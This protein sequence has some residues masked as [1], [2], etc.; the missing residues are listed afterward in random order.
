[1]EISKV[2]EI[3]GERGCLNFFQFCLNFQAVVLKVSFFAFPSRVANAK[4][5]NLV[6]LK[7][8][9]NIFVLA[10]GSIFCRC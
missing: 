2:Q 3:P 9:M 4:T 7:H 10:K 5:I 8:E 1:M 6:N